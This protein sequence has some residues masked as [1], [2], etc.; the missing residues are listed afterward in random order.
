MK[1]TTRIIIGL[2]VFLMLFAFLSPLIF[3][4]SY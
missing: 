2:L 1:K 4:Q 3:F